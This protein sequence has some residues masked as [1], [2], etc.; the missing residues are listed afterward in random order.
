MMMTRTM[1]LS[2]LVAGAGCAHRTYVGATYSGTAY[3]SGDSGYYY[4][5]ATS[6]G[7][8]ARALTG[9]DYR[10][11]YPGNSDTVSYGAL[12]TPD[13][14]A[15]TTQGAGAR[16]LTGRPDTTQYGY[17]EP[18]VTVYN[19]GVGGGEVAG[20]T[21]V[22]SSSN[23]ANDDANFIREAMQLG[24]AEVRIGELAQQKAMNSSLREF[25]QMIVTDHQKSNDELKQLAQQ[26]QASISTATAMSSR[27]QEMVDKLS[28][29]QGRDFDRMCERDLVS[30]HEKAVRAFKH[31]AEHG[32]DADLRAFAQKT[33][34]TLE[35][36]L[37][38]AK[39]LKKEKLNT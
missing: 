7:A 33:L 19:S 27:E 36:H 5:P 37:Q 9:R 26:K 8:G 39:D 32:Q 28:S 14:F 25:G 30:T 12:S 21:T 2:L 29:A 20:G 11:E 4:E 1:L 38:Q 31:E 18:G 23:L 10:S 17:V 35:Q 3:S 15:A 24:A 6:R 16:A 34:P 22:V 13:S